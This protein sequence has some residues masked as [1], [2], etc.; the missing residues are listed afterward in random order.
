MISVDRCIVECSDPAA[1]AAIAAA[2]I[3]P[4]RMDAAFMA[5]SAVFVSQFKLR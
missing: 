3:G 2:Q 1:L 4:N 5:D